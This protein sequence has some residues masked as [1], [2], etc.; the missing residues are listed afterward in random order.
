M[1][2]LLPSFMYQK[3]V[4]MTGPVPKRS[5]QAQVFEGRSIKEFLD[6]FLKDHNYEKAENG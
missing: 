1:P 6:I 2:H 3:W 5:P 4:R